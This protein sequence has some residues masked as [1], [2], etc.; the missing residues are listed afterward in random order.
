MVLL[1]ARNKQTNKKPTL[2]GTGRAGGR[3]TQSTGPGPHR[4]RPF[5][6]SAKGMQGKQ[7]LEQASGPLF[8]HKHDTQQVGK[9][10]VTPISQPP[11]KHTN[12][13]F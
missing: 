2:I 6:L 5:V 1:G 7:T 13:I 9:A 12:F 10:N 11:L 4:A 3:D 8:V